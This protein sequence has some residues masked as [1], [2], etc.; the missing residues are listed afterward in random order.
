M[1]V[2]LA[3]QHHTIDLLQVLGNLRI[4]RHAAIERNGQLRK[5]LLEAAIDLAAQR[6]DLAV[7]LGLSP[8]TTYCARAR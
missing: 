5:I 2:G 8:A 7:F 4:G 1:V 3:A 6:R